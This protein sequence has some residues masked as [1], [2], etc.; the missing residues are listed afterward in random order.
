[1]RRDPE[2]ASTN[3]HCGLLGLPT[4]LQ[5]S[6]PR[7]VESSPCGFRSSTRMRHVP[8]PATPGG[9]YG[10][11]CCR[12]GRSAPPDTRQTVDSE[13]IIEIDPAAIDAAGSAERTCRI[14][15][16]CVRSGVRAV[17]EHRGTAAWPLH[18]MSHSLG[19]TVV[20]IET[21]PSHQNDA[22]DGRYRE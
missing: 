8:G 1:V 12:R 3:T 10:A 13:F 7:S 9:R 5:G 4:V 15:L 6:E 20:W 16:P 21:D 18:H 22:D 2:C 14:G 17:R 11:V 19:G